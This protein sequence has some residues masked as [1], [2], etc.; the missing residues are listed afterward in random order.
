[1]AAIPE[2]DDPLGR[3]LALAYRQ[4]SR[5]ERTISEVRG[6]LLERGVETDVADAVIEEL[7]EQ[8]YLDDARFARVFVEDKRVLEQWGGERIRRGL[9]ARGINR[10]LVEH[11]LGE[12]IEQEAGGE[13]DRAC[14][15]LRTRFPEPP[16]ERRDRERALGLL[17]RKGY[18]YELAIDA[19]RAYCAP[20]E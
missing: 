9:Q 6:H 20:S 10:E 16:R 14:A 13:L 1:V 5:R 3:A 18:E 8:G 19:I 11:A 12:G 2:A 15:L 4:I 17:V 7:R